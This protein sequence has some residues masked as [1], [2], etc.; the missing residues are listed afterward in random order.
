MAKN[1]TLRYFLYFAYPE[2]LQLD[3]LSTRVED[4]LKA[5]AKI[6]QSLNTRLIGWI[7]VLAVDSLIEIAKYPKEIIALNAS[8]SFFPCKEGIST[9]WRYYPGYE[10]FPVVVNLQDKSRKVTPDFTKSFF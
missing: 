4:A 3:S 9:F 5:A 10:Q 7:L 8:E 6:L 1:P 2:H